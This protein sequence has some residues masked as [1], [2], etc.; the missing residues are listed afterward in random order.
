MTVL[1]ELKQKIKDFYSEHD[2]LLLSVFKFLL[3]FLLFSSINSSLGFMEKLDN[4]FV[5]LILAII[6]AV[7]PINVMTVIGCVLIIMHCYSVGIEVAGF[8]VLL[9]VLL[10]ILF[11]RFTSEDSLALV[12]T[13]AAFHFH[14]PAAVPIGGGLL[15]GPTC[16]IPS[17]C[18]VIFVFLY[19]D[20]KGQEHSFA[21][22][23]NRGCSEAADSAGWFNE[24]SGNVAECAGFYC[25]SDAG[26]YDFQMFF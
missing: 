12:L 10:M 8:A 5:V 26:V 17:V 19:A 25:S 16:A 24:K 1:L 20:S 13:P 9:I 18:G 3:A 2:V 23:R 14:I 6:C 21:G 15:K 4:I 11:L 22:E 7:L